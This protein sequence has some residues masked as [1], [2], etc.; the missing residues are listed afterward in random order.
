MEAT[1]DRLRERTTTLAAGRIHYREAGEGPPVV[2]VHGFGVN[3]TLWDEV[4]ARLAPD[5]RCILPDWP[6]GSHPEAMRED[7]DL[8]PT[9]VATLISEF[10]EALELDDVTL[11]GNDSGGALCQLLVTERPERV[12]RLVLTN[13]DCFENFPPPEFKSMVA[14]MK[15]P[16]FSSLL[17]NTLRIP[18]VRRSPRVYGALTESA[19]DDEILLAWTR[20]QVV[21]RGVRRDG[22]RF[23]TGLDSRLT[24]RAA[25]RFPEL[26]LPTLI[27]WGTADRFFPVAYA[28]RLA[29][30]I[31]NSKL[32]ELP[33]ARTFVSIDRPDEVAREIAAFIGA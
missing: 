19:V 22:T 11:V 15:V 30:T 29:E 21:D 20:P 13:C 1:G 8:S 16:G 28:H 18:A 9:G 23:G 14:L 12:G 17:A 31:P 2:F 27:I 32:V 3:G 4:A 7:A 25:E 24:L 26:E 10:L 6:L 5:A 33:G